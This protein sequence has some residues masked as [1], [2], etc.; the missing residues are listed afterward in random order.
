VSAPGLRDRLRTSLRTRVYLLLA[1]GVGGPLLVV[2]GAFTW[3]LLALDEK[4]V[5]SRLHAARA[6]AGQLTEELNEKLESLQ[7]AASA[8]RVDLEDGSDEPEH[9]ALRD[10]VVRTHFPAGAF[11]MDSSGRVVAEEPARGDRSIAPPADQPEILEALRSGRPAVTSLVQGPAGDHAYA[12]IPVRSWQGVPTGIV[13]GVVD[14]ATQ[15]HFTVLL[16]YVRRTPD[17]IAEI[18]DANGRVIASTIPDHLHKPTACEQAG[19]TIRERGSLAAA[20]SD[21]HAGR[22]QEDEFRAVMVVAPVA[23]APWGVVIRQPEGDVLA[24]VNAVPIGLAAGIV[25]LLALGPVLAWGAT[26]SITG[27]I[28]SLTSAAERIAGG[29]LSGEIPPVPQSASDE[30]GRLGAALE[31]MR[32][33]L[34]ELFD[35]VARANQQLEERVAR[36]TAELNEANERLRER[37]VA[38]ARLYEK[39][40]GAQED[41]RKRIARELHDDTSQSLAVLVMAL[42]SAQAAVKAGL[43]P[44][45]EETRAL[46][47]RTIEDVH[48]MIL[49][50]RPSVLDDLGLQSAIRWYAER[51]LAPR[52]IAARCEFDARDRRFPAAFETAVFRVCQEAMSNIARH[53]QAENVLVQVSETG[54]KLHIEIEDDGKG[55]DPQNIAKRERRPFGLMGMRERVEILGGTLHIDS[56]PGEGTRFRIE[57]PLPRDD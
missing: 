50:L 8:A 51:H 13:G 35:L 14:A 56:A 29:D 18:V 1:L 10:P 28:Q 24:S 4:L 41:E 43:Q 40:I 26:K 11:F 7:R 31:T 15:R 38:L 37:E 42:D 48:R 52:G 19:R 39:V 49:D 2:S 17:G 30:V 16:A 6:A 54:D 32:R 5:A 21:C 3:R 33:S 12:V 57:V 23:N 47:V 9:T 34:R 25:V 27:P 20:C 22:R 45:L 46:A 53:A 44:R 55:F 36:R